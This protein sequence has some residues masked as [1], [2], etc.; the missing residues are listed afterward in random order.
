M[1][2]AADVDYRVDGRAAVLTFDSPERLNAARLERRC[3]RKPG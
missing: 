2:S 1:K 3:Q